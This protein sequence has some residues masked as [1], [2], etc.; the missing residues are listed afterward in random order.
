MWDA[1]Y[2]PECNLDFGDSFFHD[3]SADEDDD[4]GL[5]EGADDDAYEGDVDDNNCMDVDDDEGA[6]EGEDEGADEDEGEGEGEDEDAIFIVDD[7]DEHSRLSNCSN[8]HLFT[9][10][11]SLQLSLNDFDKEDYHNLKN[12]LSNFEYIFADLRIPIGTSR[13]KF[14]RRHSF[15]SLILKRQEDFREFNSIQLEITSLDLPDNSKSNP[16]LWDSICLAHSYNFHRFMFPELKSI[17]EIILELSDS[18]S[19]RRQKK[20]KKKRSQKK[21]LHEL[22][23]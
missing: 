9:D 19:H 14:I 7:E 13:L 2:D 20:G 1:D 3:Y 12:G 16:T 4:E 23:Y 5:G 10:W 6:V 18:G 15:S 22:S 11:C 17:T 8:S 21:S